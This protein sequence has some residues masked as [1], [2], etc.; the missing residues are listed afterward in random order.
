[1]FKFLLF[2]THINQ[3]GF[4]HDLQNAHFNV[5]SDQARHRTF[6]YRE[7]E[8]EPRFEGMAENVRFKKI[9]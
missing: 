6:W 5:F 8:K 2:Q 1:M 4:K 9:Q 7:K 3:Y